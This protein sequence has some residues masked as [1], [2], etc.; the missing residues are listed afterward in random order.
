[1]KKSNKK[2]DGRSGFHSQTGFHRR[3]GGNQEEKIPGFGPSRVHGGESFPSLSSHR[4]T[5]GLEAQ[6]KAQATCRMENLVY[7]Q[8]LKTRAALIH[9]PSTCTQPLHEGGNVGRAD[10]QDLLQ[11]PTSRLSGR[12]DGSVATKYTKTIPKIPRDP[13]LGSLG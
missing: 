11:S 12:V 2:R 9:D 10:K 5:C 8:A 13:G 3:R 7:I 4:I 6:V 1:M